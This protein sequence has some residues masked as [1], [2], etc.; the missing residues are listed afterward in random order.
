MTWNKEMLKDNNNFQTVT[1]TGDVLL[2]DRRERGEKLQN[3]KKVKRG[4]AIYKLLEATT[5]SEAYILVMENDLAP[6]LYNPPIL[7][8]E[9]LVVE[10]LNNPQSAADYCHDTWLNC[11]R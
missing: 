11:Y 3:G 10:F 9:D 8:F 6:S 7:L 2:L 5:D 4:Y 1:N